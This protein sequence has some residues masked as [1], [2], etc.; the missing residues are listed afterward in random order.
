MEYGR[1]EGI[2]V[3]A[4]GDGALDN[5]RA[6]TEG[7]RKLGQRQKLEV[8]WPGLADGWGGWERKQG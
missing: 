7:E 3:Q 2:L 6:G 8:E 1:E 4:T 5:G